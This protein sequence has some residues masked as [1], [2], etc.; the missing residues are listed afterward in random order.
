MPFLIHFFSFSTTS[1]MTRALIL[2]ISVPRGRLAL[3]PQRKLEVCVITVVLLRELLP[4][5]LPRQVLR[6]GTTHNISLHHTTGF[7]A[8]TVDYSTPTIG[9]ICREIENIP[10][11]E[12]VML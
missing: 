5:K 11:P 10:P 4:N 2:A 9:Y 6:T 8:L 12:R 1:F 7:E 3:K